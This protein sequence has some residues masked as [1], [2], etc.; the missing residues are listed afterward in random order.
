MCL[1]RRSN[2]DV[3]FVYCMQAAM[4]IHIS[5]FI[6]IFL[7]FLLITAFAKIFVKYMYYMNN[8]YYSYMYMYEIFYDKIQSK[9]RKYP[10]K[11]ILFGVLITLSVCIS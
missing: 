5:A 1:T 8:K 6:S 9:S 3:L 2:V 11:P 7:I 10:I 4:V